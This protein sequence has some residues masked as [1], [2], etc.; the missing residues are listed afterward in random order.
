MVNFVHQV[1]KLTDFSA[2]KALTGK[3][4]QVGAWQISN[5]PAGISA[6]WHGVSHQF[7]KVLW[8]HEFILRLR[9]EMAL[10]SGCVCAGSV[11][12]C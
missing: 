5:D 8:L 6:K 1:Q 7:F 10:T 11:S 4:V 2:W 12:G 9:I 3:P